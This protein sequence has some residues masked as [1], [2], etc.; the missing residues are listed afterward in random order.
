MMQD[1]DDGGEEPEFCMRYFIHFLFFPHFGVGLVSGSL[2]G[3][4]R[5]EN[6][7]RGGCAA[8]CMMARRLA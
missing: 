1:D 6:T 4:L 5:G 8:G 3:E 7:P 2:L